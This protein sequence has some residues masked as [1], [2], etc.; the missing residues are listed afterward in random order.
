MRASRQT[1]AIDLKSVTQA[2]LHDTIALLHLPNQ[3]MQ[4]GNEIGVDRGQMTS[5]DSAEQ[6]PTK[7]RCRLYGQYKIAKSDTA[8]RCV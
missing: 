1:V 3:T 6:Q 5:D 4:I 8:G 2:R 7:P